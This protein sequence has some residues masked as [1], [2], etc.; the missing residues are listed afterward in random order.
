MKDRYKLLLITISIL[1][2]L[3]TTISITTNVFY[4]NSNKVLN[5]NKVINDNQNNQE[6]SEDNQ[7]ENQDTEEDE[8]DIETD[9]DS[10]SPNDEKDDNES[11]TDEEEQK[12]EPTPPKDD[13]P[14]DNNEDEPTDNNEDE[15]TDNGDNTTDDNNDQTDNNEEVIDYEELKK[16]VQQEII[17]EYRISVLIDDKA[18]YNHY[19]ESATQ[20]TES[21]GEVVYEALLSIKT[22]LSNM[23]Q[24]I[25]DTLREERGFHIHL[26]KNI[27]T[28]VAGLAVFSPMSSQKIVIDADL[29]LV[30]RIVYHEIFHI[31]DRY[32]YWEN[33]Q[34][35][36]FA[37]WENYNPIGFKYG[38]E[39]TLYTQYD[40]TSPIAQVT[41]VSKYAKTNVM[42]DRAELFT[43]LM[44]RTY[45]KNYMA[46]D[47]G[48]NQ[49]AKYLDQIIE[50][51]FGQIENAHW[52][53][54]ITY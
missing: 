49:K 45:K 6:K 46:N 27:P 37:N 24:S 10:E 47:Y 25:L 3:L 18:H 12:T 11:D 32:M 4:S 42:E 51:Y 20:T 38:T 2:L 36:A 19:G 8:T 22:A 26:L 7:E 54:W 21:D 14:T 16:Q 15:P 9:S 23:P 30:E 5:D 48:I 29:L 41:F 31:M 52:K 1:I 40:K 34:K 53:R 17:D 43:D 44:F 39:S 13:E 35:E 33:E 28:G 50:D